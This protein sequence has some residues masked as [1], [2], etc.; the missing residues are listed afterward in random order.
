MKTA[1]KTM[2]AKKVATKMAPK[3]KG[4]VQKKMY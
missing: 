4:M 1:I 3:K 2:A